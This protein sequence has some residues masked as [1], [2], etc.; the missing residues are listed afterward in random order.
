MAVR[1]ERNTVRPERLALRPE[2]DAFGAERVALR[3]EPRLAVPL[4]RPAE[5]CLAPCERDLAFAWLRFPDRF[6]EPAQ[7]SGALPASI[8]NIIKAANSDFGFG[9]FLMSTT[10]RWAAVHSRSA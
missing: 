3:V 2:R 1:P 10:S 8:R 4:E 6:G 9:K 7:H 5:L